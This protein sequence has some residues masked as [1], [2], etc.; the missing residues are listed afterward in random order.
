M[1]SGPGW[2]GRHP[3]VPRRYSLGCLLL[4][5]TAWGLGLDPLLGVR[6][7]AQGFREGLGER[8]NGR[9]RGYERESLLAG[10]NDSR[11]R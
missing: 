7:E 11:L 6:C 2:I 9:L 4:R 3:G 1:S 10:F 8:W 5:R